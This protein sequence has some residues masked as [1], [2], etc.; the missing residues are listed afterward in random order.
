MSLKESE[1]E[2]HLIKK[3]DDLKYRYRPDIRDKAALM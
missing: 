3:L 2:R 1:L